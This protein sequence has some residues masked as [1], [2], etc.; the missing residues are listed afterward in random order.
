MKIYGVVL[1]IITEYKYK[2]CGKNQTATFRIV[3]IQAGI[4]ILCLLSV[5]SKTT[6]IYV[7]LYVKK[8]VVTYTCVEISK[9][10]MIC[11]CS[12]LFR[13]QFIVL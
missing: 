7:R 4:R 3:R 9:K 8:G 11:N 13:I 5:S 12:E 1:V 10:T 6:S 2:D